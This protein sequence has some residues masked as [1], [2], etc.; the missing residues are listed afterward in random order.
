MFKELHDKYMHAES[1]KK[2]HAVAR[3]T[4][5]QAQETYDQINPL[6][7]IKLV[8]D[9]R[10]ENGLTHHQL[11]DEVFKLVK[12]INLHV[13]KAKG[14]VMTLNFEGFQQFLLQYSHFHFGGQEA[15]AYSLIEKLF[16]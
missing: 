9:F 2:P 13:T 5:D 15:R 4:F 6:S 10:L 11:K 16:N 1:V 7:L 12:A 14:D 3:N 8:K